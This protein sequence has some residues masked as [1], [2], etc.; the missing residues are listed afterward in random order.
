[1]QYSGIVIR[2]SGVRVPPP[3]PIFFAH[4]QR[5]QAPQGVFFYVARN[6]NLTQAKMAVFSHF[7]SSQ[8]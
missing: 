6:S 1:M 8:N 4:L 3:L 2:V 7:Q 5:F